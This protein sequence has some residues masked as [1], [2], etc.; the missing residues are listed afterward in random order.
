MSD[1]G[2][3]IHGRRIL[4]VKLPHDSS[5]AGESV[6]GRASVYVVC[7]RVWGGYGPSEKG[8]GEAEVDR[9]KA[10]GES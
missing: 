6:S 1:G 9:L 4:T 8:T 3:E 2:K 7:A 5:H 10:P